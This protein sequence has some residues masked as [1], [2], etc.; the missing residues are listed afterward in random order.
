MITVV[1]IM[2]SVVFGTVAVLVAGATMHGTAAKA[3]A[4][5]VSVIIVVIVVIVII[6]SA[7]V[8]GASGMVITIHL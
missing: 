4:T 3:S 5:A 6:A 2:A 8:R 7:A 1:I